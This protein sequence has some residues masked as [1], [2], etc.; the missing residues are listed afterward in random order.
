MASTGRSAIRLPE[1]CPRKRS[2]AGVPDGS[3][4]SW[5]S[6]A[7]GERPSSCGLERIARFCTIRWFALNPGGVRRHCSK[8]SFGRKL[9]E[10]SA[11]A[12]HRH[13]SACDDL[14]SPRYVAPANRGNCPRSAFPVL[15]MN[16]R[17]LQSRL[18]HRSPAEAPSALPPP[19]DRPQRPLCDGNSTW[20]TG[21]GVDAPSVFSDLQG[22]ARDRGV[23]PMP[24][25]QARR[26]RSRT[27]S[28]V[29][30]DS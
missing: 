4:R 25:V 5:F 15:V 18:Q 29:R 19:E 1:R 20:A 3:A 27:R 21:V 14:Q 7:G 12:P 6:G 24:Y 16:H 22:I 28:S 23:S 13:K 10:P 11:S 2:E 8:R 17:H 30:R 26:A 9:P